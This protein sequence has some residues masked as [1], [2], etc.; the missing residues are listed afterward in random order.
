MYDCMDVRICMYAYICG[1]IRARL[2]VN[3]RVAQSVLVLTITPRPLCSFFQWMAIMMSDL[4]DFE[5][6]KQKLL[7][8]FVMK[9]SRQH[10]GRRAGAILSGDDI[11]VACILTA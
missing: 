3:E 4:G 9:V 6:T 8:A 2:C 10:G 1:V 11:P 7:N 5:G